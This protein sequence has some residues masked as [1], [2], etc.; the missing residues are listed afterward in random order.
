MLPTFASLTGHKSSLVDTCK[1]SRVLVVFP[2]VLVVFLLSTDY[3]NNH[4]TL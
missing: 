3:V 2:T 4:Y 1:S